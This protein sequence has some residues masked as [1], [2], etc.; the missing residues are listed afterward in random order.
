MSQRV[1]EY[2]CSS[3]ST[4]RRVSLSTVLILLPFTNLLARLIVRAIGEGPAPKGDEDIAPALNPVLFEIPPMA[5]D[6][7]RREVLRLGER[8]AEQVAAALPTMPAVLAGKHAA[9]D[10]LHERERQIDR[11]HAAIVGFIEK[12]LQPELPQDV[13][14][15][16][17][18]LVEAADYLEAI[19]DL[20]DKEVIPLIRRHEER[21]TAMSPPARERLRALAEAVSQEL[22]RALRAVAEQDL[23]LARSVLEAKPQIRDL[24]RAAIELQAESQP[25]DGLPRVLPTALERELAESLRR[26]Y[27]LVRRFVRVGTGLLRADMQKVVE[28]EKA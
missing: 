7:A 12:M 23:E 15:A 2:D 4:P 3:T 13:C 1:S 10:P 5:L 14:R 20:I 25:V 28:L 27:S 22:R 11:H 26:G 19:G 16:A 17:I 21:G 9:L 18:D 8:V 24:E 6:A